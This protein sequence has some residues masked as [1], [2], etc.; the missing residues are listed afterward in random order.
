MLSTTI[1]CVSGHVPIKETPQRN[2]EMRPSPPGIRSPSHAEH[3]YAMC[4]WTCQNIETAQRN[5]E[6]R[7]SP[8]GIRGRTH[9]QHYYTS[10][11]L[12]SQN[13]KLLVSWG[14]KIWQFCTSEFVSRLHGIRGTAIMTPRLRKSAFRFGQFMFLTFTM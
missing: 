13:K 6:I 4:M 3:Y 10:C 2:R 1:R 12:T 8:P 9:A 14:V 5:R 11:T 7:H